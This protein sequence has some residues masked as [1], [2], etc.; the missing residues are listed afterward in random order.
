MNNKGI[1]PL[2]III[3]ES[4]GLILWL[5]SVGVWLF[6]KWLVGLVIKAMN[7]ITE[8]PHSGV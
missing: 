6:G 8:L 1:D 7:R 5:A 2:L 3:F 4:V